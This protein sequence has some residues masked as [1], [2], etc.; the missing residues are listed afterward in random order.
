MYVAIDDGLTEQLDVWLSVVFVVDQCVSYTKD[1]NA[2]LSLILTRLGQCVSE[3]LILRIT[4][5]A[6]A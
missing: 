6:C 5:S 2:S 1:I 4:F 3:M